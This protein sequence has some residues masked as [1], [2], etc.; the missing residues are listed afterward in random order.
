LDSIQNSFKSL[1][2][3]KE[4]QQR[5]NQLKRAVLQDPDVQTFIQN[6]KE[7]I[8]QEMIDRS[9]GKLYE[10]INQSKG[11][12]QCKSLEECKNI[13]KGYH[14]S[15]AI[16]G[17]TI[18]V[19]YDKCPKKEEY[20]QRKSRE[21]LVKSM[22]IPKEILH[23]QIVDIA[24]DD[25]SRIKIVSFAQD[26]IE[27]YSVNKRMKGLYIYGPFGV[28][29][30][31]VLGAIANELKEKG[32]SS[33]LVYVPEFMR[34]LKSAIHD[35]SLNEKLETVKKVPV[36]MLDDLGAESMTSWMRDDILGTILQFRMLENLPTFFT[37]NLSLDEL[38]HHLTYS[39]RGEVEELKA[40][41]VLERIKYL[42]TPVK[43]KGKNRRM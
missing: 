8:D 1:I 42:A 30:T 35:Q 41:R 6:H 33:M 18:D 24:L 28:G 27:Q 26:F 19:K 38:K 23:A 11:C 9:L 4:F 20:D 37:S 40:V 12:K 7:E 25:E 36:L 29:K 3:R 39:Q 10:F 5:L 13:I 14:P 31:F 32:I 17:K 15:L 21:S 34:E 43:M 2:G 22:Y 16:Q